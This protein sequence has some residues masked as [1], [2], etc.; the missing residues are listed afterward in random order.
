MAKRTTTPNGMEAS[1]RYETEQT[2]AGYLVWDTD[3]DKPGKRL[4]GFTLVT[5]WDAMRSELAGRGLDVGDIYHK[6][7]FS[8][9]E[10]GL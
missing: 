6:E 4:A 9:T 5:D 3:I 7:T 8:P 2:D 1:D 10:V